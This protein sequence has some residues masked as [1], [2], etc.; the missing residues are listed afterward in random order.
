[1]PIIMFLPLKRIWLIRKKPKKKQKKML[2]ISQLTRRMKASRIKK[3]N[4][5]KQN[6][7]RTMLLQKITR[8]RIK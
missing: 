8:H 6:L 7:K 3:T 5:I 1:M 4:L 2:I